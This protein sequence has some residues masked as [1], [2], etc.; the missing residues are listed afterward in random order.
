MLNLRFVDTLR[1]VAARGSFSAAARALNYTQPAV[2]RQVALLEREAGVPLVV[3]SRGGIH[4]TAAGRLVVQHAEAIRARLQRLD[5]E[6]AEVIG[7]KRVEVALGGFPTAFVGLIPAIVR[8]VLAQAPEA[9]ITL[10]RCGHDEAIAAVRRA[11]LDLALVFADAAATEPGGDVKIVDLA[12]EEMLALLPRTHPLASRRRIRLAALDGEQWIIGAPDPASSVI[13]NACRDAGFEPRIAFETDDALATQS[14]VAAGLGVSLTTPWL[15]SSL[16]PDVVLRPLARPAPV[17]RLRA[18]VTEPAGPGAR[19]LLDLARIVAPET[20]P[21][22][23]P[24]ID[25]G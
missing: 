18:V 24:A 23:L 25:P 21:P 10:R 2:S 1:E 15:L 11:E 8:G 7:G 4:L 13:V 20:P 14:L 16:R 6:L 17:R 22:S 19:L 12:D 9:A 3:R 5:T